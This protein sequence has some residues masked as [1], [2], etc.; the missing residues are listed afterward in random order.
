M[1][2][3]MKENNVEKKKEEHSCSDVKL[4]Q[5]DRVYKERNKGKLKSNGGVLLKWLA[6]EIVGTWE[7]LSVVQL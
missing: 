4:E 1:K 5:N 6:R 7:S 3:G 2:E